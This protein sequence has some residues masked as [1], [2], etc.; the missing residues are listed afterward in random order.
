MKERAP[1]EIIVLPDAIK[2][3]AKEGLIFFA[4]ITEAIRLIVISLC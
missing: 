3:D 2:I 1:K 4:K